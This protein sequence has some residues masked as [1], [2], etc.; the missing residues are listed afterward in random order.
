[1]RINNWQ[2]CSKNPPPEYTRVEIR[3]KDRHTYIGYRYLNRYY[4]TFGNYIIQ[5]PI[6]WR[7]IPQNSYLLEE[8]KQ[9]LKNIKEGEI[10]Y[11]C[12]DY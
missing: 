12:Q 11:G 5:D 2:L 9:R 3:D 4:E 8:I 1:M 10:V 6:K 7:Y